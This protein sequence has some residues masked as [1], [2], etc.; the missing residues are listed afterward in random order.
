[1]TDA[2]NSTCDYID[3]SIFSVT[4]PGLDLSHCDAS[5]RVLKSIFG[6]PID[7]LTNTAVN[8]GDTPVHSLITLFIGHFNSAMIGL[9]LL[10][11]G[12]MTVVGVI[13]T[14]N[15]G[16][17]GGRVMGHWWFPIRALIPPALL[18]PVKGGF[19]MLQFL[20][21]YTILVGVNIAN[22]VW[23][24]SVG[25]IN[26]GYVPTTPQALNTAVAKDVG[27]I[28]VYSAVDKILQNKGINTSI[29]VT[30]GKSTVLGSVYEPQLKAALLSICD[31]GKSNVSAMALGAGYIPGQNKPDPNPSNPSGGSNQGYTPNGKDYGVTDPAACEAAV[32]NLFSYKVSAGVFPAAPGPTMGAQAT[33]ASNSYDAYQVGFGST[34]GSLDGDYL[35]SG[36]YTINIDKLLGQ[37]SKGGPINTADIAAMVNGKPIYNK[38]IGVQT[39]IVAR[40]VNSDGLPAAPCAKGT[41]CSFEGVID[42]VM[43][44]MV[45]ENRSVNNNPDGKDRLITQQKMVV[46]GTGLTCNRICRNKVSN[47]PLAN[48]N[49]MPSGCTGAYHIQ[50]TNQCY[51]L[52][53]SSMN[54]A[55]EVRAIPPQYYANSWWYG[56]QVYLQLN[57]QM[58]DNIKKLAEDIKNFVIDPTKIGQVATFTPD[59]QAFAN[60]LGVYVT[61]NQLQYL[62]N[63]T[64]LN[65]NDPIGPKKFTVSFSS[66][67]GT[68]VSKF[69]LPDWQ[70][71]TCT[72]SPRLPLGMT[73]DNCIEKLQGAKAKL[74][75]GTEITFGGSAADSAGVKYTETSRDL[76][77]YNEMVKM[78]PEYQM[79]MG[80]LLELLYHHKISY[81]NLKLYVNNMID[82]LKINHIYPGSQIAPTT[83]G[84]VDSSALS[85]PVSYWVGSMFNHMLGVNVPGIGGNAQTGGLFQ[86]IYSLGNM[87]LDNVSDVVNNSLNTLAQAQRIGLEM[88]DTVTLSLENVYQ[89]FKS[90]LASFRSEDAKVA[91]SFGAGALGT[92]IGLTIY[93]SAFANSISSAIAIA[94]QT[95]L[96]F[97]LA[98]Q[99]HEIAQDLLWL[100]LLFVV[101]TSLFTAGMSFAL[102]LPLVPFI[103]FW[104][105]QIAWLL[106]VIEAMIAVPLVVLGLMTPGG[107]EHF[108]HMLPGVKMWIALVFRPALMVL[109]LLVGL[110]LTYIVIRF[111]SQGF[112]LV[113]GEIISYAG[114]ADSYGTFSV[115]QAAYANNI[116][117]TQGILS[118]IMLTTF[119]AFMVLAFNKCFSAIYVVPEKVM[120][121]VG[122]MADKAGEQELQQ[123]S[124]SVNQSSQQS[125][126]A[127]GQGA[128]KGVGAETQFNQGEGQAYSSSLGQG[129]QIAHQVT[130]ESQGADAKAAS[131]GQ[132]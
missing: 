132:E 65:A 113:A 53:P 29:P 82:I 70:V 42:G 49:H 69:A 32:K 131:Q 50:P 104:A 130:R 23:H 48:W 18:F 54:G 78:P 26:T 19:C 64:Q 61:F 86:D 40:V 83:E 7:V 107:H 38:D 57:K 111:S 101:L 76:A 45:A 31:N 43:A 24:E 110:V 98:D 79:P 47:I 35:A 51:Q 126:Q 75:P 129:V 44:A 115:N 77:F 121:W 81:D 11:Y 8:A 105:G 119:C 14:V 84:G 91:A 34:A 127:A 120:Q 80:I 103:L 116:S 108:G 28:F 87:P 10:V 68:P 33:D 1:M 12:Y 25:D 15:E 85:N 114:A 2:I 56:S 16:K 102:L 117:M 106:A 22:Q 13:N 97:M 95:T 88:I 30:L 99:M 125:V 74:A 109:G 67:S 89:H 3:H 123:M 21:M 124:S 20:I 52:V 128:E 122:A 60:G 5:V 27:L 36:T 112:Q 59:K 55:T 90:K 46:Q 4:G 71:L 17:L 72:L 96:Q 9:A 100:P 63:G 39:D 73:N 6:Q 62:S 92:G 58:A 41:D 93:G 37:P 66:A 118:S 94:G